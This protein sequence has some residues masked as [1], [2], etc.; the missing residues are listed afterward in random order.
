MAFNF[1]KRNV[2]IE[3]FVNSGS[4]NDPFT[5]NF[6]SKVSFKKDQFKKEH[7]NIF[8]MTTLLKEHSK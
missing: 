4:K 1:I 6:C 8:V 5:W 2:L 7:F 3:I